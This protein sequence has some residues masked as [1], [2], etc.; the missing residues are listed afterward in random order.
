MKKTLV[1]LAMLALLTACSS[2]KEGVV[3]AKHARRGAAEPFPVGM[4]FRQTLPGVCW[5]EVE[6]L[7]KRGRKARRNV[8]LFRA[9]WEKIRVGDHWTAGTG[10]RAAR[11]FK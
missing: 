5:A 8:I 11:D 1:T 10:F 7:D 3:I 9:S 6:G 4:Q 2:V